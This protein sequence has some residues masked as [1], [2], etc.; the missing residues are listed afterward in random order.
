MDISFIKIGFLNLVQNEINTL[1]KLELSDVISLTLAF[2]YLIAGC[3]L[4]E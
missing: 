2:G 1:N 3:F 4:Q